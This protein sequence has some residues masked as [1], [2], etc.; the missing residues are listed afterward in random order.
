MTSPALKVPLAEGERIRRALLEAGLLD[1][2]HRIAVDAGWVWIPLTA[3]LPDIPAGTELGER[4]FEPLPPSGPRDYRDLVPGTPEERDRLPRAFDV[5]GDIVLIRL[6]P[7]LRERAETIGSALLRFVPGARL[8]A[9]DRGVHG[10]ERRRTLRA[11][12]GTGPFRTRYRENG[13][14]FLVDVERCYFSPRLAR[15]HAAFAERVRDGDRVLDLCC[16]LGPFGL[17]AARRWPSV[18][19]T[20]VDVNREAIDL[21][22]E[23]ARRLGVAERIEAH[24]ADAAELLPRLGTFDRIV[25]NL[26][27]AG[28][29]FLPQLPAHA[30]LPGALDYFEVV[31]RERSGRRAE[32]IRSVLGSEAWRL[33]EEVAVHEYSPGAV[34]RRYTYNHD[35]GPPR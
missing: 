15:E 25:L 23:N 8:V 24:V 7:E 16:G 27:H 19:V 2:T 9:E 11:I 5:V 4:E 20:A 18:R 26:P 6:P 12:A 17:T 35:P 29:R 28:A 3:R 22:R 34:L 31:D 1:P 13:L 14:E 33:A 30:A 10:E 21:L 32:E